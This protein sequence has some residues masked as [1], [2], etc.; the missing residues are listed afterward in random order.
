[1]NE[2]WIGIKPVLSDRVAKALVSFGGGRGVCRPANE[3]YTP[4]SKT[5]EFGHCLTD[6]VYV[7]GTD[8]IICVQAG[9]AA[10]GAL[11][12]APGVEGMDRKAIDLTLSSGPKSRW[13][14]QSAGIAA[15]YPDR[16]EVSAKMMTYDTEPMAQAMELAGPTIVSIEMA[17]LSTDPALFIYC[18]DVAPDGRVTFLTE[19]Q[20]RAIQRKPADPAT[21]PYDQGPAPHSFL[22][23]DALPVS[24]GERIHVEFALSNVAARI[25]AGHRLRIAIGGADTHMFKVYSD[26]GPERFDIFRGGNQGS[27]VTFPL[28]PWQG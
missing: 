2:R 1:M 25:A 9:I 11:A 22:R 18:E 24:S 14:T 6:S 12:S 16:R 5:R 17:S 23:A 13:T 20:F 19:G 26:G 21:L 15:D 4:M 3:A 8:I 7:V 28:M 27:T 10:N